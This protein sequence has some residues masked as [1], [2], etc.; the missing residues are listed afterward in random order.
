MEQIEPTAASRRYS[1]GAIAFHWIIAILIMLNFIGAWVAED[2]A[3]AEKLQMMANHKAM[4]LTI[5]LL[6][7]LRL[8]WRATHTPP[9]LLDSLKSW[10]TALAKVVHGLFYVL[11]LGIPLA[12]WAMHSAYSGGAPVSFFGLF[13]YPGLPLAQAKATAGIFGE[14]H[15]LFAGL[16]LFLLGLHVLAALKHQFVDRDATMRR[17]LP[18]KA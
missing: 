14:M 8:V 6:T 15:E 18:G 16:M 13:D 5:L 2:A 4:G 3:K 10:E 11:M 1:L 7:V 17:I 9:P 12:G